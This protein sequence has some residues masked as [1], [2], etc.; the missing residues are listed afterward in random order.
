MG[1]ARER[2]RHRTSPAPAGARVSGLVRQQH[3][4]AWRARSVGGM[5]E[6]T[7]LDATAQADLVRRGEVSPKELTEAAIAGIE[8]VNPQLD[9]VIRTRFDAAR[10]EAD[11]VRPRADAYGGMAGDVLPRGAVPG[12]RLRLARPYQCAGAWHHGD[13]RATQLPPGA[14]SVGSRS[15]DRWLVRGVSRRG[16]GWPGAGG[17]RQRRRRL[18]PHPGERVRSGRAQADPR[19]GEPGPADRGGMGG[20]RGRRRG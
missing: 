10:L 5:T 12:G 2:Q 20:R 6:T 18:H 1:W 17:A 3:R 8:A 7:W 19:P 13:Y 15:F 4:A 14:Q 9:A 11:G 16:G